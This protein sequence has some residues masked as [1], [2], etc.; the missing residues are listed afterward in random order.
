MGSARR[1]REVRLLRQSLPEKCHGTPFHI[2]GADSSCGGAVRRGQAG[3]PF[4]RILPR[5]RLPLVREGVICCSSVLSCISL[6]GWG[7]SDYDLLRHTVRLLKSYPLNNRADYN[8][9]ISPKGCLSWAW[10][11]CFVV[12]AGILFQALLCFSERTDIRLPGEEQVCRDAKRPVLPGK[13]PLY[14]PPR[15]ITWGLVAVSLFY[16]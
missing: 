14:D 4:D 3:D 12:L 9:T 16:S 11:A 6:P 8:Y 13:V 15:I 2:S 5:C 1:K 7:E 10:Q